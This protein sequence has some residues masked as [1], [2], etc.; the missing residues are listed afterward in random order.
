WSEQETDHVGEMD[1]LGRLEEETELRRIRRRLWRARFGKKLGASPPGELS[2]ERVGARLSLDGERQ[3]RVPGL[4]AR[5]ER[6]IPR[7]RARKMRQGV[8]AQ[9]D[10]IG[11]RDVLESGGGMAVRQ[12]VLLHP[13]RIGAAQLAGRIG[14]DAP[15]GINIQQ[16]EV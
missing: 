10:V 2:V 3:S 11:R 14:K 4:E 6:E 13:R 1:F 16:K 12:V 15:V 8:E 7:P 5:D 9:T